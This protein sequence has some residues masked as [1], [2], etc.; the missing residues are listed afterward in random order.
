MKNYPGY[1]DLHM[2]S[3]VSDGTVTPE[4]LLEMVRSEGIEMF[5]I[6][7]HDSVNGSMA[8]KNILTREDPYFITGVEFSC[9]DDGGKY[10]ILGYNYDPDS[11]PMKEILDIGHKTRMTKVTQRIEGL[12]EMF[13]ITFPEE[14]VEALYQMNSPGKPHIMQMMIDHGYA[15]SVPEAAE[16]YI[17]KIKVV[18]S[19]IAPEIAIERILAAGGIPVLAHPTFGNGE[20]YITGA[21]MEKIIVHL[22]DMGLQGIEAFYS[23]FDRKINDELLGYAEKYDLYVTAGSDYHGKTKTVKLGDTGLAADVDK[24][25]GMK[26][27]LDT[28]LD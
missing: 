7:D 28:V 14:E 19:Y 4:K 9:K 13:G 15:K 23:G 16:D 11:E 20:V 1:I 27:F 5:S 2:H 18:S 25:A 3:T 6:T 12:K 17:N 26:R 8:V 24:P 22:M 10:H 21:D